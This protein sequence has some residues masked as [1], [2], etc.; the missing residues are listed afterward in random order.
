MTYPTNHDQ[1]YN[2]GGSTMKDMYGDNRYA[3][4]VLEFT[5][6]G[7]PLLY[8]G[9]EIGD[10]CAYDYVDDINNAASATAGRQV[11]YE[12][13]LGEADLTSNSNSGLR[14]K[15]FDYD[16]AWNFQDNLT[17]LNAM[18]SVATRVASVKNYCNNLG[19][20]SANIKEGR[21]IYLTNH[22]LNFNDG[23]RTLTKM[24]G[25]NRYLLTVLTFTLNGM[26]LI[27]NGQ[28]TGGSQILDYFNDT[29]IDWDISDRK[30][31]NTLRILAALKHSEPALAD[32][33]GNVADVN[34]G[35][36]NNS[37]VLAYTR[38][39]GNSTVL[40]VLNFDNKDLNVLLTGLEAGNYSRWIDSETIHL[41]LDVEWKW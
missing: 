11:I 15:G 30:M 19:T 5:L 8:N 6:Y 9:Q 37:S 18:S 32:G 28:E 1:N 36:T 4:T 40:V 21:M 13:F 27:Y 35:T 3:L 14:D 2:G 31:F 38:R 10:I 33:K 24:Y 16:Y 7:M 39:L 26:P 34:W 12:I 22:D 25:D 23:G 41:H 20:A 17:R 29:K